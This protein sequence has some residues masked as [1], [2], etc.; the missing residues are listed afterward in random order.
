MQLSDIFFS[1]A[2]DK[3]ETRLTFYIFSGPTGSLF[4]DILRVAMWGSQQVKNGA[5]FQETVDTW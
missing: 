2:A 4:N 3:N 1:N 5:N